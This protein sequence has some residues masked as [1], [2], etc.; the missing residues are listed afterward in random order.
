LSHR[1]A[2]QGHQH[3]GSDQAMDDMRHGVFLIVICRTRLFLVGMC[4]RSAWPA[5]GPGRL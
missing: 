3:Q 1:N 5:S 4:N 2:W